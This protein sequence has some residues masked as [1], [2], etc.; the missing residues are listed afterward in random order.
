MG[1]LE[2]I[3]VTTR[4]SQGILAS[5]R[6][7]SNVDFVR[8]T[9]AECSDTLA[10]I[11]K[12]M[13]SIQSQGGWD[14]FWNRGNNIRQISEYVNK[15]TTVQRKTLDLVVLLMGGLRNT[16]RDFHIVMEGI[17]K[18]EQKHYGEIEVLEF[19]VKIKEAITQLKLTE[20]RMDYYSEE[21]QRQREV[22]REITAKSRR[23]RRTIFIIGALSVIN[24][25]MFIGFLIV[26]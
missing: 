7:K 16:K 15:V 25:M 23:G 10:E 9:L 5:D 4:N 24:L 8:T 20:E 21:L 11:S 22:L 18:L 13:S 19:L 14:S 6:T 3:D 12:T 2:L 17:D 1:E 26:R